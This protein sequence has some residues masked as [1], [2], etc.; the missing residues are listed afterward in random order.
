MG[1]IDYVKLAVQSGVAYMPLPNA[2]SYR[3]KQKTILDAA[4]RNLVTVSTSVADIT[5]DHKLEL[6][7][8]IEHI[9]LHD[10]ED[11]LEEELSY[12]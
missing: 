3:Q 6:A 10:D 1:A 9:P 5:F 7:I 12:H 11:K 2:D 8:R 4:R